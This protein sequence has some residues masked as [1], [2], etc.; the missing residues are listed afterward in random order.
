MMMA[1]GQ[2][3]NQQGQ[4][5]NER[6]GTA[7]QQRLQ[8]GE[9]S[10]YHFQDNYEDS[11]IY[12]YQQVIDLIPRVYDTRRIKHILADDG[13]EMEVE[14]DPRAAQAYAQEMDRENNVIRR[15]F[16]PVMGKYD[17]A[18]TVGPNVQTKRQEAVDALTMILTEAPAL[19][20]IIGDI[21]MRN[22]EFDD[23]QEAALR[24][25]RLVPPQALGYGPTPN[26]QQQALQI[27]QLQNSLAEAMQQQGKDALKLIGKD[28]MRDIDV[29]KAET[30]RI[31][32]ILPGVD[33]AGL[34]TLLTQL[35]DDAL[36]T[37][38]MPLLKANIPG[39]GEQSGE[40]GAEDRAGGNGNEGLAARR[41]AGVAPGSQPPIPG[42]Q[43][44][45]DGQWYIL[46]PTRRTRYLRVGP[47]IQER[48]PPGARTA[49]S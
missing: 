48:S 15:V 30:D 38:L 42:A 34:Q 35:I 31:K 8:Q 21:L 2:W 36:Q 5:G 22:L 19:T 13:T 4:M 32:A 20:S 26:E 6:T 7:I 14:I 24:L 40:E 3:A 45:Q 16:N 28:Q 44:A 43:Q 39:I 27:Q 9:T 25:K 41:A 49:G 46:D 47:L 1:S 29:Y 12:T 18:A 11:L 17:V 10:T 33:P 37:N 23:A